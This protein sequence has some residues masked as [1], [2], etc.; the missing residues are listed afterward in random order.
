MLVDSQATIVVGGYS[1]NA[2]TIEHFILRLPYHLKLV[3]VFL[4]FKLIDSSIFNFFNNIYFDEEV[5]I[6]CI[7]V[8]DLFKSCKK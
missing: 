1:L 4:K 8:T 3:S 5:N 2:I 7:I 6:L